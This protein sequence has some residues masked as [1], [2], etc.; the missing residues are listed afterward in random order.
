MRHNLRLLGF[1]IIVATLMLLVADL[2]RHSVAVS[3]V[4]AKAKAS[5]AGFAHDLSGTGNIEASVCIRSMRRRTP[6]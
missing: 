5:P 3:G 2:L 1:T 6:G 4:N